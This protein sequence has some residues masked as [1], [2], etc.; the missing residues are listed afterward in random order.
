MRQ[1]GHL[2]A[3]PERGMGRTMGGV[4]KHLV[5]QG[6]SPH[7]HSS[8]SKDASEKPVGIDS[9]VPRPGS[10]QNKSVMGATDIALFNGD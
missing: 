5:A 7:F 8:I 2:A 10:G 6:K 3:N 9:C 4:A 1:S